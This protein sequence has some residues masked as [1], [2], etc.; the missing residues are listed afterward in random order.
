M[1]HP[2]FLKDAAVLLGAILLF[3]SITSFIIAP[4]GIILPGRAST[5]EA[6]LRVVLPTPSIFPSPTF[7]PFTPFQA[8]TLAPEPAET[9]AMPVG[10]PVETGTAASETAST[11]AA[12]STSIEPAP[13]DEAAFLVPVDPATP[14]PQPTETQY[15]PLIPD[16]IVIPAIDLDAPVIPSTNQLVEINGQVFQ[17]WQAP[18]EFAAGWHYTSAYLGSPGNTVLDGHHNIYGSVFARLIDLSE[19]DVIH[20]SSGS[21]TFSYVIANKM[22]LPERDQD[23]SVRLEN[24]R[25]LLPS[26][27][28]PL[29]L[30][31][32]W[33]EWSNTHRLIIVAKP[34]AQA[35]H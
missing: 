4:A 33:P 14:E 1:R 23:I 5:D 11:A 32:C 19:G 16:R 27:D 29:T 13:T 15:A 12:V 10:E 35:V 9:A 22:L 28:E 6:V 24:A 30:I 3:G 8:A 20:V 31:T 21:T 25:W 7:T 18:S 34:V 17:Q 2:N 26:N